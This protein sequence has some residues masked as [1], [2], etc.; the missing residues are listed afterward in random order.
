MDYF[1]MLGAENTSVNEN[2]FL[3]SR[4]RHS[5]DIWEIFDQSEIYYKLALTIDPILVTNIITDFH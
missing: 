4:N 2:Q 3:L 1:S 5:R